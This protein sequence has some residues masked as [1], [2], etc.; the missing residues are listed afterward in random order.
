MTGATGVRLADLSR[1]RVDEAVASLL[2]PHRE[3]LRGADRLLVLAD[4]TYPH[5]PSTGTVAN[6]AV[7]GAVAAWLRAA[8]PDAAVE[9]A[10]SGSRY[11]PDELT[12]RLPGFERAAADAGAGVVALDA[13]PVERHRVDRP[14][15][16]RRVDLPRPL[17]DAAVVP[18]ASLRCGRR[19]GVEA[20][21][22]TLA[23]AA[24]DDPTPD[25]RAV[26]T[27]TAAVD[28]PA[29]VLDATYAFAGEPRETRV[30]VAAASVA[31][32]D[33][34]AAALLGEDPDEVPY[35]GSGPATP[36][37]I[38]GGSAAAVAAVLPADRDLSSNRPGTAAAWG[39]RFYAWLA[40]DAVPPQ[41]AREP[42]PLRAAY[43]RAV[44]AVAGSPD[45]D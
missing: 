20:A 2:D 17:A 21:A 35:L 7:V 39:Y 19:Y 42:S 25:P 10:V 3:A 36:P 22:V 13:E 45:R 26:A 43:E 23:A 16:E 38:R 14:D 41:F 18:V 37:E 31:G 9:V 24:G 6:P 15:G 32:V 5:H 11:A 28:V 44:D 27:A 33:R 30:L 4:A 8:V 40:G 34:A 29:A 1:D 12:A